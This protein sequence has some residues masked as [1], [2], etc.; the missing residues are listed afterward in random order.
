MAAV[1]GPRDSSLFPWGSICLSFSLTRF[2]SIVSRGLS[3]GNASRPTSTSSAGSCSPSNSRG[4]T[5]TAGRSFLARVAQEICPGRVFSG[6]AP[7][8]VGHTLGAFHAPCGSSLFCFGSAALRVTVSL[9][10]LFAKDAKK[11]S[12]DPP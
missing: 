3:R 9:E 10:I 5:K 7:P 6:F 4:L 1:E 2:A 8:L 12:P 11:I